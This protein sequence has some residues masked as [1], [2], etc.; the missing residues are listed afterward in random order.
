MIYISHDD[1][2]IT[3]VAIEP[4]AGCTAVLFEHP[5]DIITAP[6]N[7]RF[8]DDGIVLLPELWAHTDRPIRMKLSY[9]DALTMSETMPELLLQLKAAGMPVVKDPVNRVT[10]T[11]FLTITSEE[12]SLLESLGGHFENLEPQL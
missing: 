10:Y 1:D 6:G 5:A 12:R 11:Y 2:L 4:F 8:R 7:Y 3:K 9:D